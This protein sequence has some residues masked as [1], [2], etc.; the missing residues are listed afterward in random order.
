[1]PVSNIIAL[2]FDFDDTL[3]DDSTTKLLEARG[4]N[5]NDFWETR[6]KLVGNGWDPTLGYLNM[7]I[8]NVGEDKP[9]GNLSNRE[10][11]DFGSTLEFYEGIPELFNDLQEITKAHPVAHPCIEFYVISG[12]LEETI[13]GSDIA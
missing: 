2:I 1:M 13:K 8:E 6:N 11:R 7:I 9:L 12:G 10:L 4:I 5:S 3:T